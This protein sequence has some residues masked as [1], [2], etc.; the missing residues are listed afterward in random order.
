MLGADCNSY[1]NPVLC[2]M[3]I[4]LKCLKK[5]KSGFKYQLEILRKDQNIKSPFSVF[6]QNKFDMLEEVTSA[7]KKLNLLKES[8]EQSLHEHS[9]KNKNRT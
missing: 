5:S 3:V 8:I 6:V 4:K 2:R 9:R 1:H 7:E